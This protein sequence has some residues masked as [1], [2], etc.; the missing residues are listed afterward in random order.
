MLGMIVE[1]HV[2]QE[3]TKITITTST[4]VRHNSNCDRHLTEA[5]IVIG[6]IGDDMSSIDV[7]S[8]ARP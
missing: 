3:Q 7:R 5:R 1:R 8:A 4:T 2:A 6:A